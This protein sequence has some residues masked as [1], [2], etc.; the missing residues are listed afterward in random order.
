MEPF[1][2]I[3]IR[4]H[5]HGSRA[6]PSRVDRPVQSGTFKRLA[7]RLFNAILPLDRRHKQTRR[8]PYVFPRVDREIE[9]EK[10][11]RAPFPTSG[12]RVKSQHKET[13]P[14]RGS[15]VAWFRVNSRRGHLTRGMPF[16]LHVPRVHIHPRLS[17]EQ[18]YRN[19]NVRAD[20]LFTREMIDRSINRSIYRRQE[21]LCN[22]D[23]LFNGRL[24]AN[25]CIL[26]VL[27][28]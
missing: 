10:S 3:H 13:I 17:G 8:R 20:S 1:E 4:A 18:I 5:L 6:K 16:I 11:S 26:D 27:D 19:T 22:D 23:K 14:E 9:R 28:I 7:N 12:K 21:A 15:Q 2:K 25:P 24:D